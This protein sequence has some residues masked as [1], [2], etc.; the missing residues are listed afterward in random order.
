MPSTW[1]GY[2]S[3]GTYGICSRFSTYR[4]MISMNCNASYTL[5]NLVLDTAHQNLKKVEPTGTS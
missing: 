2:E 3:G 1:N 5:T 4:A